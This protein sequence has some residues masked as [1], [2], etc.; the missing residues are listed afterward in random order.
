MN[1]PTPSREA[2]VDYLRKRV[3]KGEYAIPSSDVLA[4]SIF[5]KTVAEM[6]EEELEVIFRAGKHKNRMAAAAVKPR[7]REPRT[8]VQT[9]L[10]EE[11]AHCPI[12]REFYVV[13]S[14]RRDLDCPACYEAS[15]E[16]AAQTKA[17]LARVEETLDGCR[18]ADCL[19]T[20]FQPN[21]LL[22]CREVLPSEETPKQ[23]RWQRAWD[24]VCVIAA[25]GTLAYVAVR[26]AVAFQG[27]R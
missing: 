25:L 27:G 26:F 7:I 21:V 18:E 12:H 8:P 19:A 13:K 24:W 9:P 14:G 22:E 10:Y 2:H 20:L 16:E 3:Q 4:D 6:T 15:L 23:S 11:A 5:Q 1:T 17:A